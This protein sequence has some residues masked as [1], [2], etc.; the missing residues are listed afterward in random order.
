VVVLSTPSA[1]VEAVMIG[2]VGSVAHFWVWNLGYDDMRG[3][4]RDE[5]IVMDSHGFVSMARW[6][7]VCV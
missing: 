3:K 2:V 4:G 7:F 6:C 1:S 5:E